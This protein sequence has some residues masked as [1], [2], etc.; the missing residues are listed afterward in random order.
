M[1]ALEPE[2]VDDDGKP[3]KPGYEVFFRRGAPLDSEPTPKSTSRHLPEGLRSAISP[4][5]MGGARFSLRFYAGFL[6]KSSLRPAVR[7]IDRG[8]RSNSC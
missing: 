8:C 5:L 2:A 3:P 4:K 1:A 7:A 6:K